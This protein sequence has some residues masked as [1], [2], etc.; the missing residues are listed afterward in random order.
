MFPAEQ[1]E[2]MIDNIAAQMKVSLASSGMH[3][4]PDDKYKPKDIRI[5]SVF[6]LGHEIYSHEHSIIT[7]MRLTR[8]R[9]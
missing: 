2:E 1:T 3:E 8:T 7:K 9:Y 4:I 5:L 6:F